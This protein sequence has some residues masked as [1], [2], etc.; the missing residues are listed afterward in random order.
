MTNAE[1]QQLVEKLSVADFGRP[2]QHQATL[3]GVCGQPVVAMCY[4]RTIWKL[5]P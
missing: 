2:F 1:L 5:T 4:K 3:T